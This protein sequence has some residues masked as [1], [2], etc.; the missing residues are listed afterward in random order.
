MLPSRDN[1]THD[2]DWLSIK[3]LVGGIP[4]ATMPIIAQLNGGIFRPD[5]VSRLIGEHVLLSSTS[6]AILALC[7]DFLKRFPSAGYKTPIRISPE[8]YFSSST[9]NYH[10]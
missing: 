9:F 3:R 8:N 6:G 10:Q 4:R 1:I 5:M 7:Y 2:F